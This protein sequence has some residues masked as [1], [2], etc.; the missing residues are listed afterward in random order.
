MSPKSI[1][2]LRT[3]AL[4]RRLQ[5][6]QGKSVARPAVA[7]PK[8]EADLQ[9]LLQELQ[10]HQ[11]ELEL[12]NTELQ[13]ARSGVEILLEKYT[14]LYDF[15][16]VGYFSLD[17][18]GRII[19]ANLTG[20]ALLGVERSG[21]INRPLA[22]YVTKASR[23]VISDFLQRVLSGGEKQ[24]C[25]AEVFRQNAAAF[26][27]S[28][29]GSSTRFPNSTQQWCRIAISDIT[30]LK[31]AEE[32][33]RRMELLAESNR[34]L[35]WEIARRKKMQGSLKKSELNSRSLLEQSRQMQERL[36]LL[37]RQ[38]LSVQEEERKKISRELHDVIGQ[39]LTGINV[40]LANLKREAG[41]DSRHLKRRIAETQRLVEHS[42]SSVQRFARELRPAMLDDLGLIPALQTFVKSFIKETGLHVS[43][44]AFSDVERVIGDRRTVL[45]RIAQEALTNVVRHAKATRVRV[46]IKKS[47][48]N[49]LMIIEDNGKGFRE[50]LV[51]RAIKNNR[52]GL[53][54]MK[55]RLEMIG[56]SL[57]I[58]SAKR[59]GT[60]L[61][62]QIPP[63][64]QTKAAGRS[65]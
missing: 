7:Q 43:L 9:R 15:A 38:L 6:W 19:E 40:Q 28:F 10:V 48:S 39:T 57:T 45:Y 21:L 27:G 30:S 4:R 35:R 32:A 11:I 41:M 13:D 3:A 17:E 5:A 24:V 8:T 14:D 33:Q 52:L 20:A 54:G 60:I 50:K 26:W 25:E 49:V 36:R 65:N 46:Q 55:E 63:P 22:H 34:D 53:L 37:S 61:C 2:E 23:S 1:L 59:G 18:R 47:G 64:P 44:A 58:S 12:Q 29:H 51:Q 31:Q 42:V 62:A 16:P 56:G